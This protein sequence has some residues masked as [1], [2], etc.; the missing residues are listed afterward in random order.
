MPMAAPLDDEQEKPLDP[1]VER[2]RRKLVRFVAINLGLLFLALMAVVVAIVYRAS[3][4]EEPASA[5][6][7]ELP[8][9]ADRTVLEGEIALPRGAR[10]VSHALSGSVLS[11]QLQLPDGERSIL[12]YDT[13]RGEPVGRFAVREAE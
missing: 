1:A 13:V 12:L 5:A 9:P 10:I 4:V 3:R 6:V 11:L 8:M 2:V 7:S